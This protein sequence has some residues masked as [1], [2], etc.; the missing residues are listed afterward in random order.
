LSGLVSGINTQEMVEKLLSGTQAKI[1]KA[2][3]K[4]TVLQYKQQMYRDV[5]AKL[6]TLQSSF[7]SFTSK[8]NLLSNAFYNTMNA[9]VN[10][11]SG[12]AAAFSVTASST[13]AVGNY[14]MDY[15]KQLATAYTKKTTTAATGEV[16][17]TFNKAAAENLLKSY[18]G[19]DAQ[20]SIKVGDK[21]VAITDV[22]AKFGGKQPSEIVRIMNESFAE[23]G[24]QATA[25]FVNNK[26]QIKAHNEDDYINVFGNLNSEA[27]NP[28]LALKMFGEN[29][30]SL[31]AQGTFSAAIDT[32][33]YMPSFTVNLDGRQQD[34]TLNINDLRSFVADGDPSALTASV[35]AELSR[36]FGTGVQLTEVKNAADEVIGFSLETASTSQKVT[37]TGTSG[38]MGI[39]GMKSGASNKVDTTKALQDLNFA[40]ELQGNRHVFSINGTE[41][42]YDASVSLGEVINDINN[43]KAGV[44]I[45]YIESED[46]FVIQNSETGAVADDYDFKLEQKEGNL[47]SAL[48][49]ADGGSVVT[50]AGVNMTMKGEALSDATLSAIARGG[51]Y[52]FNVNGA[53]YSFSVPWNT[54]M[55]QYTP[56]DFA[57]KMNEAFANTFGLLPDGTQALTFGYDGTR[58]AINANDKNLV[59][60]AVKQDDDTNKDLLGFS[61]GQTNRANS[62]D[63]TL[64]DAGIFFGPSAKMTI[65]LGSY[66]SMDITADEIWAEGGGADTDTTFNDLTNLINRKISSLLPS[67]YTGDAP[68]VEYDEKA[69]AFRVLGV[70]IPM[71]I[72]VTGD[73]LSTNLDNIFG[74]MNLAVS[75]DY[76]AA[77]EDFLQK[78]ADGQN[79][80][81]KLNGSVME[82]SSNNFTIDGLTYTLHTANADPDDPDKTEATQISV[83]RDTDKI[84]EG[85]EEFLKL[86]NETIDFINNLY[87]AD[88]TYKDYAP[89]TEAQKRDMSDRE[90]ELWEE[91]SKE[92]LLRND[93]NLE[94]ILQGLRTA[95]YTKPE[96]SSIAIYDLGINTSYYSSDGNFNASTLDNLKAAIESDPEAVR[97]L[98]AGDG[99]IMELVNGV[100]NDATN[101]G[102]SSPGWLTAVAGTAASDVNSSIRKQINE[103]DDQLVTLESRYWNEYNRYWKQFNAMEQMIQNMNT[104]SSWLTQQLGG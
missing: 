15:I 95:M 88:A 34:I 26:L 46:R 18:E 51:V 47:L 14:S 22:A 62:G 35:S 78:T 68:R 9:T 71:E 49:G 27:K 90:I 48:F 24:V 65:N 58:F 100:I 61:V 81:F 41:F 56:E 94:R 42:A 70:D 29:N 10:T 16:G 57:K 31:S 20:M 3:Q 13:A 93:A 87:R 103:I 50:G 40:V 8:T 75:Q 63:V 33:R 98:F 6:K 12:T 69:A 89:L 73:G 82:R 104:Q 1:D 92:G 21:V 64:R 52:T 72:V 39:L 7:L 38:V 53:D 2:G 43:S 44:K 83:T 19:A 80:I 28:T 77:G 30:T 91:K 86:Y 32:D 84:V 37:V 79:A 76:S 97:K 11:P 66:G 17:G 67:D 4:K 25:S 55:A 96:G 74:Q 59:V 85:I 5:A 101:S 36:V 54:T 99:G 102:F 60:K 45:S 23:A